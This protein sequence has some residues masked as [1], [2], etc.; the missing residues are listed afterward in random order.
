MGK[1]KISSRQLKLSRAMEAASPVSAIK[2]P[3]AKA[4]DTGDMGLIPG[5]G[6]SPRQ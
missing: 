3:L 1:S 6:R 5:T 4:G 2:N